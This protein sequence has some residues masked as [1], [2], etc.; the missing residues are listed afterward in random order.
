[1]NGYY[2]E[3]ITLLLAPC[4]SVI[5]L[6]ILRIGLDLRGLNCLSLICLLP[7]KK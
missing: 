7:C 5:L 2:L 4:I 6:K 1:M 3:F